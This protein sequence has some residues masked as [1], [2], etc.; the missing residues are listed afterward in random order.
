MKKVLLLMFCSAS[1]FSMPAKRTPTVVSQPDGTTFSIV[2]FG[3]ER[4]NYAETLDGYVVI[5]GSDK[6]WYYATLGPEG[7]FIPSMFRIRGGGKLTQHQTMTSIP[8]HLAESRQ[9]ILE[10]LHT[11]QVDRIISEDAPYRNAPELSRLQ[12]AT[13]HVLI[14]CARFPDLDAT[15]TS[16]SFQDMVNNDNWNG[17]VGGMSKYYKEV[18]YNSVS[19]QAD[20]QDWITAAEP[21]SYYAYSNKDY[22]IHVRELVRQCIDSAEANGVNFSAYDNDGDGYVDGLFIVHAGIGAEEGN[23]TQ[24][25][26]SHQGGLGTYSRSYDGK[27]IDRYI[28]MPELYGSGHVD[29]GVFCHEYGH[30]LGLPDLYDTD[31]TTNG[32]SEGVG[33]WCL[34]AGGSWGGNGDTPERPSHMSAYCKALL[35][36]S[37]PTV[38]AS[39]QA[40]T[41][42]QAETNPFSYK[43]WMDDN[44]SD[45]YM[46]IENRQKTG[47][48]LNLPGPGLLIYHV[49][50]NLADIW[51]SSNSI[52]VT[53]SHLGAKVYEADGLEEMAEGTNRGNA[54]DPYPGSTGNTSLTPVSFPSTALW[55]SSSS[56]VEITDISA[57]SA[58]MT[59]TAVLPT[60]YGYNVQ[61]YRN[62]TG[63]SYGNQNTNSGY[64]MVKCIPTLTGKLLGIRVF[65]FADR[66]TSVSAA[67]FTNF[68]S[69]V[70]SGQVGNTVSAA[71]AGIT[72]FL[73]LNFS[74]E[75][76]VTQNVPIYIRIFFQ[77]Q[78]GGFAVP[79][80]ITPPATGNSYYSDNG[81]S[82]GSLAPY[83]I[84][85]RVVFR[86][87][88]ALPVQL[89]VFAANSRGSGVTLSWQ[90]A[91]EI[92]NFG[93]EMEKDTARVPQVFTA[94]P[95]SFIPGHGTTLVPHSYTFID[96]DIAP[97][98]W[99]Y[100][101][102][103]IDLDGTIHLYDPI[104][105]DL[106][107]A[108]AESDPEIPTAFTLRQNF[109]NPFNP[110]TTVR[111]GLPARSAVTLMVF[112]TLGQQ[113][114]LLASGEQDAGYHD[115]K[116]EATSLSSGVYFCRLHARPLDAAAV[117]GSMSGA[118][119]YVEVKK[120]LFAR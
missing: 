120:L 69:G 88:S 109:P 38:V 116:F 4:Y 58:T 32:D 55:N 89:T 84:A 19:I 18:S 97:G 27:T 11:Y 26:W 117:G 5:R 42:P 64:G 16:V 76:D 87:N 73:Q 9:V 33:N 39:S 74:P 34:M 31:G 110:S 90:T 41:I 52:N 83:D 104:L 71:S 86:S 61:F 118:G 79:I 17:G 62:L 81:T 29:I 67:A 36:Y 43:I 23:Q 95:G 44:Q 75:I 63:Y 108:D 111:Y 57:S 14:L 78:T 66:Y 25:I 2:G 10:K 56:G 103:Q 85:A 13:K 30:M 20:Y 53:A 105:V 54:G 51:A 113:V 94:I 102:K 47:F 12:S 35:G 6:Y 70:L 50:K 114:A 60:Y 46:L 28:I 82:F 8:K 80:D 49:D 92:D 115:V 106:T 15:Q 91:S 101:L 45:E 72:N 65:S 98:K 24:Y 96:K 99:A 1:L 7:R 21:S 77:V 107:T 119:E 22:G 40:L 59:A 112:N 68:S 93:F 100:R 3:D 48:D 37:A